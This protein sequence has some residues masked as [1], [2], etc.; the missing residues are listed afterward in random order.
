MATA[1]DQIR[2]SQTV[3]RMLDQR[4]RDG[5]SYNDVLERVLDRETDSNLLAGFGRWADDH[6][7]RIRNSR[8]KQNS[9]SKERMGRLTENEST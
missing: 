3:K 6:A 7:E 1:D 4:R 9:E 2:V 8:E 5:E